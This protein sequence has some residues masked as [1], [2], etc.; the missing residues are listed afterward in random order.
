MRVGATM[1]VVVTDEV[2]REGTKLRVDERNSGFR[3]GTVADHTPERSDIVDRLAVVHIA[4]R[5]RATGQGW[6]DRQG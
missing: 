6:R 1:P 3:V 4:R 5:D 2:D